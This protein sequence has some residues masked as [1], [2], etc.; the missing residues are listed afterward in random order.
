MQDAERD[1][2]LRERDIAGDRHQNRTCR[3]E[4]HAPPERLRS[5]V[6]A[7]GEHKARADQRE[8]EGHDDRARDQPERVVIE[9]GVD[10]AKPRQIEGEVV[11]HHQHDADAAQGIDDCVPVVPVLSEGCRAGRGRA[12]A[13]RTAAHRSVRPGEAIAALA[14][15]HG[16]Q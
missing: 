12:A 9:V 4:G 11:R 15:G 7:F 16:D 6:R 8:E 3:N 5:R 2:C 13:A 1:E 14:V 10:D